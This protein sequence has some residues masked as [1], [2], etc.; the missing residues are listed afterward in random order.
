MNDPIH[1]GGG[2][3]FSLTVEAVVDV[4]APPAVVFEVLTDRDRWAEWSTMLVSL[5]TG[6]I[7]EGG[8]LALGLRTPQANYDFTAR[9][10]RLAPNEVFEWLAKTGVRGVMDGR[11]R[12]E[13][14]PLTEGRTRLRNVETYSG[15]LVPLVRRT[16]SMRA[17]PEGFRAMNAEIAARAEALAG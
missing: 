3:M 10:T 2:S 7:V 15:L 16:A 4:S 9:V 11:H 17:A 13:L 5:A 12:F 1:A 6:P 14:S 8:S